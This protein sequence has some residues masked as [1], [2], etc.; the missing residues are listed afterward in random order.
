[1]HIAAVINVA[2]GEAALSQA[3]QT[4]TLL[5]EHLGSQLGS[6]RLAVP[7][8]LKPACL[9]ALAEK[10]D[11][12]VVAG[13]PRAARRA[14]Q[15]AYAHR[16]PILF[17]PGHRFP[18]WA[19]NLWGSLSLE[20]MVTALAKGAVTPLH[21]PAGVAAGQIFFGNA[22]CGGLPQLRQL[23]DDLAEAETLAAAARLFAETAIAC[24]RVLRPRIAVQYEGNSCEASAVMVR[25][26]AGQAHDS[27]S[28]PLGSFDCMVW[29]QG[30]WARARASLRAAA[31]RDWKESDEPERFRCTTLRLDAGVK[32][33]LLL[34]GEAMALRGPVELR[35]LPSTVKTFAFA[36]DRASRPAP[37]AAAYRDPGNPQRPSH[38]RM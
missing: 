13:G 28:A 5:L 16:L 24:G 15:I 33:R 29:R 6:I 26:Q 8:L 14:G 32:T 34:D 23:R 2:P 3:T 18:S 30:P 20:D 22:Y 4:Q 35:Y 37:Y 31:G 19:R 9:G 25:A 21:L 38:V 36:S 11:L 12:L 17:L 27:D 10:P 1:M 7:R